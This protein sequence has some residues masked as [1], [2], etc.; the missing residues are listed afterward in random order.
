VK[1]VRYITCFNYQYRNNNF[2]FEQ[3]SY[4]LFSQSRIPNRLPEIQKP[5]TTNVV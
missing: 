1:R 5:Y 3:F 4:S 2:Y